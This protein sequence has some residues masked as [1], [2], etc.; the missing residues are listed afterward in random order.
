MTTL[1]FTIG[2]HGT[3]VFFACLMILF[4]LAE[5]GWLFPCLVGSAAVG[6]FGCGLAVALLARRSPRSAGSDST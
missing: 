5:P 4:F 3:L 2:G 1:L 6:L